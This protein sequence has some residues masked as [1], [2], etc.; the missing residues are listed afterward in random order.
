MC[1]LCMSLRERMERIM[2]VLAYVLF[3]IYVIIFN[4][5]YYKF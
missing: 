1:D 4:G 2:V 3:E 5:Q